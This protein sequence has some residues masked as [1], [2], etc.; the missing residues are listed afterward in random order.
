MTNILTRRNDK[1][2]PSTVWDAPG[3]CRSWPASSGTSR[4]ACEPCSSAV[5]PAATGAPAGNGPWTSRSWWYCPGRALPA[6]AATPATPR[7]PS[8]AASPHRLPPWWRTRLSAAVAR[9]WRGWSAGRHRNRCRRDPP[10]RRPRPQ[11]PGHRPPAGRACGRVFCRCRTSRKRET[12]AHPGP[13][14]CSRCRSRWRRRCGADGCGRVAGAGRGVVRA[15][16]WV[17]RPSETGEGWSLP[18]HC[19]SGPAPC[20][21]EKRLSFS[22]ALIKFRPSERSSVFRRYSCR[23]FLLLQLVGDKRPSF[24][25]SYRLQKNFRRAGFSSW[26]KHHLTFLRPAAVVL[27][28]FSRQAYSISALSELRRERWFMPAFGTSHSLHWRSRPSIKIF[29]PRT[30]VRGAIHPLPKKSSSLRVS[31]R[32]RKVDMTSQPRR[33]SSAPRTKYGWTDEPLCRQVSPSRLMTRRFTLLTLSCE[34]T[35]FTQLAHRW[36]WYSHNWHSYSNSWHQEFT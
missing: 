8:C 14:C 28:R 6:T 15:S 25:S 11:R 22:A 35:L 31:D 21:P 36:H 29:L 24:P 13:R 10:C 26:A 30:R 9:L 32:A 23:A 27:T 34:I 16:R 7:P 2:K 19:P 1:S 4:P 18:H 12:P 33:W 17:E 5:F 3:S 20:R